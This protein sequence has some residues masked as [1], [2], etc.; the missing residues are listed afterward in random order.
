M[1]D[2]KVQ[3]LIHEKLV[4]FVAAT[5]GQGDCPANMR[6][7]WHFLLRKSL[8]INSLSDLKFAVLGLGDSSYKKFNF[9]AKKLNK[10][11]LQLGGEELI[12]IGLADDQHD[13]G[14]DAVVPKWTEN[15]W[16]KVFD[17]FNLPKVEATPQLGIIKRFNVK[18]FETSCPKDS[19]KRED[20]YMLDTYLDNKLKV[21]IC[22]HQVSRACG[23]NFSNDYSLF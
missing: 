17:N 16:T 15:L 19:K 3:N 11:L 10:R 18:T 23:A 20:I 9:A 13:M 7:F 12:P 14:I 8:P 4:V 21:N 1:D 6:E 2:Y 22:N 5:C